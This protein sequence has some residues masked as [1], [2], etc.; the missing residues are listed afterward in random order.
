MSYDSLIERPQLPF[1]R[2]QI[3]RGGPALADYLRQ[4]VDQL[5][6]RTYDLN[7]Y[8]N[9]FRGW[10]HADNFDQIDGGDH[11]AGSIVTAAAALNAWTNPQSAYTAGS[12]PIADGESILQT[13]PLTATGQTVLIWWGGVINYLI[14]PS[15]VKLRLY[16]G[17]EL[18]IETGNVA[19][20][21]GY[22]P[23][24]LLIYAEAPVSGSTIYTLRALCTNIGGQAA[25][26]NRVLVSLECKR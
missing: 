8:A 12:S 19:T 14:L 18:L 1:D 15:D 5:E 2:D 20:V 6:E 10:T 11:Y 21:S 16:R 13:L 7:R 23:P 24:V 22:G 17:S 3:V 26:S 25:V 4:L 9:H